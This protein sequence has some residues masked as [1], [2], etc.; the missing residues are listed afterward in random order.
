MQGYAVALKVGLRKQDLDR[1]VGIHPTVSEEFV[2]LSVTKSS[3]LEFE[4]KNC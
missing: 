3:G 1:T 4:K 2:G